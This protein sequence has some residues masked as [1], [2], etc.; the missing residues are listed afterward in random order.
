VEPPAD[1]NPWWRSRIR[2]VTATASMFGGRLS[3]SH[4]DWR[5]ASLPEIWAFQALGDMEPRERSRN[6]CSEGIHD[7]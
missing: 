5:T 3:L 7:S 1:N 6:V 2:R 4:V